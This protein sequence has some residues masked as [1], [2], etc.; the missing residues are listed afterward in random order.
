MA[1]G[2][3]EITSNGLVAKC[4]NISQCGGDDIEIRNPG[5]RHKSASL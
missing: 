3:W 5:L 1:E 2:I 4:V